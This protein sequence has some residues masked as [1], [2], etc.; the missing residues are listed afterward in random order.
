MFEQSPWYL[1]VLA[2]EFI[3]VRKQRSQLKAPADGTLA[4]D[5]ISLLRHAFILIA[6]ENVISLR[7]G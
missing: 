4:A 3:V 1:Q 5:S 7:A 2:K 6:G